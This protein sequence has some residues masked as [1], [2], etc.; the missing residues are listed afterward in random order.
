MSLVSG[1]GKRM[2]IFDSLIVAYLFLGSTGGGALAVLSL[3]EVLNSPRL[4]ARRWLLPAE[5]FARA[6]AACAI[7][8]GLSVVCLLADLGRID[9]AFFLFTA[10]TPSA[11]AVGAWSLAV[12]CAL[13]TV[14]ACALLRRNPPPAAIAMSAADPPDQDFQALR[15][16]VLLPVPRP[17]WPHLPRISH[18]PLRF[19]APLSHAPS[20]RGTARGQTVLPA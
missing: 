3:L 9:R 5:F 20:H 6:W 14:F 8:L 2:G 10:S 11:I 18:F 15:P 13:S 4:A 12:A 17:A 19:R 7:V 1:E 16:R